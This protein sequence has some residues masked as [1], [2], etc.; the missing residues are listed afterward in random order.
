V[1]GD[2]EQ[3]FKRK[4]KRKKK[5]SH[6]RWSWCNFLVPAFESRGRRISEFEESLVYRMSSK[7]ARAT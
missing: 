7:R 2:S 1:T 3:I 5:Y 4:K 6:G